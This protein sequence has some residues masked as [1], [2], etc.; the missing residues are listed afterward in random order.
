MRSDTEPLA[1][2][3]VSAPTRLS[4]SVDLRTDLYG[5]FPGFGAFEAIRHKISPGF[6]YSY[7]PEVTPTEL[8][9]EV[10]N[11][12][13]IRAQRTL[14]ISLNQTWEAK[15]KEDPNAP[16]APGAGGVALGGRPAG[17]LP[18]RAAE[19]IPLD[20]LLAP[21]ADS[22]GIS[23]DSLMAD[24]LLVDS[25]LADSTLGP[26]SGQNQPIVTLLSLKT[27]AISYDFEKAAERGDWLWGI[28]NTVI[29]NT[30]SSDYLRGLNI[31]M[32][33]DLFEDATTT[34]GDGGGTEPTR[35]FSPHLS[36]L[37][38]GFSLNG[39]SLPFR[40]LSRLL[41][42][43]EDEAGQASSA[44]DTRDLGPDEEDNPFA[45]S[46][47]D[48]ASIIPG[49]AD[50]APSRRGQSRG[51]SRGWSANLRFSMQRPRNPDVASNQMIQGSL[52]FSLTDHWDASWRTSYDLVEGSFND[53]YI[54]LTR[55]LHRWEAHFDFRKSATGNWQFR[56]EVALLDQED[57]HFD[58]SQR[59][60]Q[61]E[62][63]GRRF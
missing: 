24:T 53:H 19:E 55:D 33:H 58:Y 35:K 6:N 22:M 4:A 21:M 34:S 43:G 44:A 5:F 39:N 8:Q 7:S 50:P 13:S 51:G 32:A 12:D 60:Y 27:T 18:G 17:G 25:L 63:G 36:S 16:G 54:Q 9:R 48:E 28:T 57:L 56:F 61:T 37:N 3:F 31:T 38:F 15:R 26:M 29:T 23:L 20:S 14:R 11:A 45:P 41:A 59:S 30:L 10:F 46:L 52:N 40:L 49:G 2:D 62:S 47:T 1:Q 42:G